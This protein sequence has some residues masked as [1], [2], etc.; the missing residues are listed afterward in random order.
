MACLRSILDPELPSN[1]QNLSSKQAANL[2]WYDQALLK[3]RKQKQ[4]PEDAVCCFELSRAPGK[5][6]KPVYRSDGRIM[7]LTASNAYIWVKAFKAP[8]FDR[9]LSGRERLLLQGLDAAFVG[10]LEDSQSL[11]VRATGNAMAM[12]CIGVAAACLWSGFKK[13]GPS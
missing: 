4:M 13:S 9:F 3:I 2:A 12:P 6:R 10:L 5:V 7:C 8:H 11:M 1:R